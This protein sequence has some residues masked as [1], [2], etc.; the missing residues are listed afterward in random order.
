V[1]TN[2]G[3]IG[4]AAQNAVLQAL[5]KTAGQS[6]VAFVRPDAGQKMHGKKRR[7]RRYRPPEKRTKWDMRGIRL[8]C[9]DPR[10]RFN[11]TE[12]FQWLTM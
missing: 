11:S 8:A 10:V 4:K 6:G 1:A 2:V 9:L 5:E 7:R 3:N 12:G